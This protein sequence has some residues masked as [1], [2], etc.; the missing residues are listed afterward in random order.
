MTARVKA[1][2]LYDRLEGEV[3]PEIRFRSLAERENPD[4]ILTISSFFFV[5]LHKQFL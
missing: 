3:K 5:S 4:T 2:F 1:L